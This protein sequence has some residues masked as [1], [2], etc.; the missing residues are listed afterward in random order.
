MSMI[1]NVAVA[2][3]KSLMEADQQRAV[4]AGHDI[5]LVI[6]AYMPSAR[7]AAVAAIEAMRGNNKIEQAAQIVEL[8]LTTALTAD[9]VTGRTLHRLDG[10][11]I[12]DLA[13]AI[14]SLKDE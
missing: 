8:K 9:T 5:M 3:A 4:N 12:R 7:V 2:I 6:D 13:T 11:I 1:E 10:A 14:R